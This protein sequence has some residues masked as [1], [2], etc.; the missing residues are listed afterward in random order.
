MPG[1]SHSGPL[2]PVTPEETELAA[3]LKRHITTI[4]SKPHNIRY[5]ANLEAAARYIEETLAFAGY[6]VSAQR[7]TADDVEVRNL[8]VTIEPTADD[9][10]VKTIVVGAHYDSVGDV[11][12][13][14][15]NGSGTAAVIELAR[16]LK[17]M[18]P[19]HT[20]LRLVLFVNE[21][22]PYFKTED[23]GS[24]R[25]AAM[26]AERHEPVSAMI[27]LETIGYFS[28]EPGSQLYPPPFGAILPSQGNFV[29]FVGTLESR[30]LVRGT[31]GAFRRNTAFPTV[32]GVAPGFI[33]GIDWSDHWSFAQ[34]GFPAIM[35]TDT[36]PFRYFHY[37]R[38]SDTPDKVDY[39][40]L[41]RIT[42][43]ME[44]VLRELAQ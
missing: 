44:R 7:Y 24:Y 5:A 17:D 28:E 27:T 32:G 33:P 4:A 2:P 41:A 19:A 22:P 10:E 13:A 39:E 29:A 35:V 37:H 9:P 36:A 23:M 43:G 18:K 21:E 12:G 6:S 25:Y 20:R 40:S 34:H 16:L 38:L 42:K 3:R 11:P 15:D 31:I 14:N 26:M 8:E 30:R 1:S